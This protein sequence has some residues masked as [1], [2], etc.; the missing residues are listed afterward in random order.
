MEHVLVVVDNNVN[1][2]IVCQVLLESRGD[3]CTFWACGAD[4]A[5]PVH[6]VPRGNIFLCDAELNEK[7]HI[8]NLQSTLDYLQ[9]SWQEPVAVLV[10]TEEPARVHVAGLSDRIDRVIHPNEVG[11]KLLAVID[12]LRAISA[13]L[14]SRIVTRSQPSVGARNRAI[15]ASA[16][17]G[18]VAASTDGPRPS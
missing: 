5:C 13:P 11:G 18:E 10:V 17:T 16:A 4:A 14:Y 12:A 6:G 8:Q 7:G 15:L 9:N 3:P 1:A 2:R